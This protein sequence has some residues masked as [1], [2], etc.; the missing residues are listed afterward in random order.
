MQTSRCNIRMFI[1][2]WKSLPLDFRCLRFVFFESKPIRGNPSCQAPTFWPGQGRQ[3]S[4]DAVEAESRRV[5]VCVVMEALRVL[6]EDI[7]RAVRVGKLALW[8]RYRHDAPKQI[9]DQLSASFGRS[10]S[11][12]DPETLP[13]ASSVAPF[14]R[15]RASAKMFEGEIPLSKR[16]RMEL[17]FRGRRDAQHVTRL[18]AESARRAAALVYAE[19]GGQ[20]AHQHEEQQYDALAEE[21][22]RNSANGNLENAVTLF[23]TTLKHLKERVASAN[24][25]GAD[26]H[27]TDVQDRALART[28]LLEAQQISFAGEEDNGR[29][30]DLHRHWAAYTNLPSSEASSPRVSYRE[31]LALLLQIC[32]DSGA[33]SVQN[34]EITA[35]FPTTQSQLFHSS[36]S[37]PEKSTAWLPYITYMSELIDYLADFCER[38]MPLVLVPHKLARAEEKFCAEID[39]QIRR[40]ICAESPEV[41]PE[42]GKGAPVSIDDGSCTAD[43][44]VRSASPDCLKK[45][46]QQLRMKCGGTPLQRAERLLHLRRLLAQK[47]VDE[48]NFPLQARLLEYRLQFAVCEVLHDVLE[49]TVTE[50]RKKEGLTLD[51]LEQER[52]RVE[53]RA[54][55]LD[56]DDSLEYSS[57]EEDPSERRSSSNQNLYMGPDGRPIPFWLYKLRGLN[58]EFLCEI[59]GNATY[60]GPRAFERHFEDAQHVYGLRCL[61]I[62]YSQRFFMV[63]RIED[64]RKLAAKHA[65]G[66]GGKMDSQVASVEIEDMEGNVHVWN[67][68]R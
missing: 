41:Q 22:A 64:A 44:L 23:Y 4:Q 18:A 53:Q 49:R 16:K 28:L 62:T 58:Q 12:A 34:R 20:H 50:V 2:N 5:C 56:S 48:L 46:L 7:E 30:L 67:L 14:P 59:C 21:H 68:P 54:G 13:H 19:L 1:A 32:F 51:E 15:K 61:G 36:R 66:Q 27:R 37:V 31:Y 63:T 52:A 11:D 38:T 10:V 25:T 60:R 43:E 9:L 33:D 65:T 39:T 6:N 35:L 24:I 45:I 42:N 40:A 17:G 29:C 57:G 47:K 3:G 8:F 55:R 26:A